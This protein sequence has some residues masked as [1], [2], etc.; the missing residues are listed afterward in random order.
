M[1]SHLP[2]LIRA[3][4]EPQGIILTS[5]KIF[6]FP[7]STDGIIGQ[8]ALCKKGNLIAREY[9]KYYKQLAKVKEVGYEKKQK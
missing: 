7:H 2:L 5:A 9:M 8:S 6:Q 1:P 4:A 3:C